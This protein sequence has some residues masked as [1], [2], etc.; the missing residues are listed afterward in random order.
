MKGELMGC[1]VKRGEKGIGL[2]PVI[3]LLILLAFLQNLVV[4]TESAYADAPDEVKYVMVGDSY[5]II[6]KSYGVT[7]A[8]PER[9]SYLLGI[10]DDQRKVFRHGGYGFARKG[11][12]FLSLLAKAKRDE[13]VTAVLVVG[14]AGNDRFRPLR[15]VRFWYRKTMARLHRLYPNAVIMHT[16]TSWDQADNDYRKRV[17]SR[18]P[19]YKRLAK[20][21]D[22]IFLNSCVKVLRKKPALFCPDNRHPT[23]KGQKLRSRA[24]ARAIK[25][26]NEPGTTQTSLRASS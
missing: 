8:W 6:S 14:G 13:T 4:F 7:R 19:I 1:G 20:L 3:S 25:N 17:A 12:R 5:S 18:I 26:L 22:V 2:V 15:E 9:V 24:I 21:N 10:S 11:K 16:V 23:D